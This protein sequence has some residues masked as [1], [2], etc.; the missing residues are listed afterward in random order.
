MFV[1]LDSLLV[2]CLFKSVCLLALW[3]WNISGVSNFSVIALGKGFC[4]CFVCLFFIREHSRTLL[5]LSQC[6]KDFKKLTELSHGCMKRARY[7]GATL[8]CFK[9][10]QRPLAVL[11]RKWPLRP[12]SAFL[13]GCHRKRDVS[14]TVDRSS[15]TANRLN[16]DSFC[17]EFFNP[18]RL[19]IC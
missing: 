9:L 16:Y 10:S 5:C 19:C 2:I 15:Q 13:I 8:P 14:K 12:K 6:S 18:W 1:S 17:H 3:R 11:Q 7:S 4:I